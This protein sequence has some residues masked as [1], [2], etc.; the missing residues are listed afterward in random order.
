MTRTER[1]RRQQ[2]RRRAAMQRAACLAL[3]FLAVAAAFAW[4]GRP[5]EPET[6]EA[7]VPVTVTG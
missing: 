2:R 1:R 4:S 7:T 6:P 3:A 5:Q